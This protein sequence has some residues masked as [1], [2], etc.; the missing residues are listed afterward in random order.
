VLFHYEQY[1]CVGMLCDHNYA[2]AACRMS[3]SGAECLNIPNTEDWYAREFA[4]FYGLL[5]GKAQPLCY[6]EFFSPVFILN[7]IDRS[8]QSGREELVGK[9]SL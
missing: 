3:E 4:E 7:A 1:D 2:Y 9:I 5:N 6:E 8:L